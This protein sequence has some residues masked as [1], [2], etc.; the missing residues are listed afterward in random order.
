MKSRQ[1]KVWYRCDPKKNTGCKKNTCTQN[2]NA[3]FKMCDQTSH[4]QFAL[5]D[6]SGN[7]IT[8]KL[9]STVTLPAR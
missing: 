7:P 8:V 3:R 9:D 4:R 5:L 6:Q 2:A 1:A